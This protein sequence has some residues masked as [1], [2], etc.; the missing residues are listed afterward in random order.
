MCVSGM[1]YICSQRLFLWCCINNDGCA[2]YVYPTN[3]QSM[4]FSSYSMWEVQSLSD[5][6]NCHNIHTMCKFGVYIRHFGVIHTYTHTQSKK[7]KVSSCRLAVPLTQWNTGVPG[8]YSGTMRFDICFPTYYQVPIDVTAGW[9][10]S[11]V[12]TRSPFLQL[13]GLEQCE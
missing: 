4:Y 8:Y 10:A 7:S 9:G 2:E 5:T 6:P 1:L 13:G 11:I 3:I 12:N